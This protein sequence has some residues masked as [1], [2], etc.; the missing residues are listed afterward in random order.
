T[1]RHKYVP[2]GQHQCL[3]GNLQIFGNG[4][5]AV[6]L[7][8]RGKAIAPRCRLR[9]HHAGQQ[10]AFGFGQVWV[11]TI[12]GGLRLRAT[13]RQS[14]SRKSERKQCSAVHI[15]TPVRVRLKPSQTAS[16]ART[17]V[18]TDRIMP[19]GMAAQASRA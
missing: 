1:F 3:T 13:A 12:L 19:P 9:N 5:D 10:A 16:T 14:N 18:I 15:A 2:I 4:A 17:A 8:Y 11:W 7:G 6:T